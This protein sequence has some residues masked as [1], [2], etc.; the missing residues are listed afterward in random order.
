MF[1]ADFAQ[2]F[3][4]P[5][6]PFSGV[7]AQGGLFGANAPDQA[8]IGSQQLGPQSTAPPPQAPAAGIGGP[9]A[10]PSPSPLA[11]PL[12]AG[13]LQPGTPML[14]GQPQQPTAP[15]AGQG[16]PLGKPGL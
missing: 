2:H 7:D 16:S 8:L 9:M 6:F 11:N 4:I 14:E 5:E 13:Q 10:S 12:Q 3:G 1:G 15:A